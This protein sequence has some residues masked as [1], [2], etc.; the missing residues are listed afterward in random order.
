LYGYTRAKRESLSQTLKNPAFLV[1]PAFVLY[2]L[3]LPLTFLVN[4]FIYPLFLYIALNVLFSIYEIIKVNKRGDPMRL[5]LLPIL[6]A[7]IHL[8]YGWGFIRGKT[9]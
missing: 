9:I 8:S 2:I 6:F 5:I 4:W 1:P 7:T 3:M